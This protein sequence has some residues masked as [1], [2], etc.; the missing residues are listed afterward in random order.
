MLVLVTGYDLSESL[1]VYRLWHC[2]YAMFVFMS[3]VWAMAEWCVNEL[4]G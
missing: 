4:F 1:C 3:E 2:A